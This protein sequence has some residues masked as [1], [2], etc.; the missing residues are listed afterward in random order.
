MLCAL[1]YFN[2][3]LLPQ[4]NFVMLNVDNSKWAPEVQE[5]GVQGIPHFVFMD[6]SGTPLAAA[7]GRLP[8][9]VLQGNVSA[10]AAGQQQLPYAAVRGQT[11]SLAPPSSMVASPQ[12]VTAPRDHV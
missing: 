10:L 2:N 7:V 5:Y 1:V 11:S 12:P 3:L 4:V 9:E 8:R 6:G